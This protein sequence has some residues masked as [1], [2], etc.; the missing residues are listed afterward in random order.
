MTA[1]AVSRRVVHDVPHNYHEGRLLIESNCTRTKKV[2]SA[3]Y[4]IAEKNLLQVQLLQALDVSR[5][6]VYDFFQST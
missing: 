3:H 2:A 4:N 1:I 5:Y 6:V